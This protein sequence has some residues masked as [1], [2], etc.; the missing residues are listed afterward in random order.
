VSITR[1]IVVT[2]MHAASRSEVMRAA[3]LARLPSAERTFVQLE[4]PGE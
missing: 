2:P 3:L 1:G 4:V